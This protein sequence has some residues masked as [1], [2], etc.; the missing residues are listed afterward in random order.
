MESVTGVEAVQ[1]FPDFASL[2]IPL[3]V[4]AIKI[5]SP[6]RPTRPPPL[7]TAP[8][9]PRHA[10]FGTLNFPLPATPACPNLNIKQWIHDREPLCT[11]RERLLPPASAGRGSGNWTKDMQKR[12]DSPHSYKQTWAWLRVESWVDSESNAFRLG[13]DLI[14]IEKWGS[15]LSH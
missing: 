1:N 12:I 9:L 14:W 7:R 5:N 3:F 13:H 15:I 4:V 2:S 11:G 6:Q 10:V 8:S